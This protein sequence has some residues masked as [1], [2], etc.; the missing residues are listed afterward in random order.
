META[1]NMVCQTCQ[2]II[3]NELGEQKRKKTPVKQPGGIIFC[4]SVCALSEQPH[5]AALK[6]REVGG[7]QDEGDT[8]EL[9]AVGGGERSTDLHTRWCRR[10]WNRSQIQVT[11]MDRSNQL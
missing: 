8:K 10:V 9:V 11:P 1:L 2:W 6:K 3:K 4:S 5:D 7:W